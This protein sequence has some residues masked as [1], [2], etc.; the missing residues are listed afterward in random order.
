[1]EVNATAFSSLMLSAMFFAM[2]GSSFTL[3]VAERA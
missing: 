3:L 1:L 2:L